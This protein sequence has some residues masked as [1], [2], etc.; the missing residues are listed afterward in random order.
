LAARVTAA[1]L[2]TLAAAAPAF[3]DVGSPCLEVVLR[4]PATADRR[5]VRVEAPGLAREA[6]ADS[7]G[8][9]V[10]FGLPP[11]SYRVQVV[12]P[13]ADASV[14]CSTNAV[15]PPDRD[16]RLELR[17]PP[18]VAAEESRVRSPSRT[19]FDAADLRS[20]PRP[21]NAWSVLREA[22]GVVLDR[23]D[24]GGSATAL[25]SLL[26][27]HGD[28][29]TG[30]TW[31]LDGVDVTDPA[32]PG[33]PLLYPPLDPLEAMVAQTG[34]TDVHARTPGVQVAL[35]S[36]APEDRPAGRLDVRF[37]PDALQSDNL[38]PGLTGRSLARGHTEQVLDLAAEAGLPVGDR[39]WVW[40]SASRYALDQTA[41][42]GHEEKLRTASLLG[43]AR[44][45]LGSGT[46]SALVLR[47]EKTDDDRD[48]TLQTAPEARWRQSGATW[49]ASLRDERALGS[50]TLVSR[51]A[52]VHGG[53]RLEPRGGSAASVFEDVT[54][55]TQRSY[56]RFET[57]RERLQAGT[58]ATARRSFLGFRHDLTT[59]VGYQRAP[60]AIR[61]SWPGNGT[62]GIESGGV[63]F[64]TFRLTGFAVA[65]RDLAAESIQDQWQA[66]MQ[67]TARRGRTTLTLGARLD[68]LAGRNR[69]AS[70]VSNPEFPA[71][72]PAVA[73][74]GSNE[75]FSWV[76]LLPRVG[77][78]FD[79]AGSGRLVSSARYAAYAAPLGSGDVTF[80][81]PLAA[82][83]STTWYWIDR[84]GDHTVERGEL[85]A[86]R[87]EIGTSGID[88]DHPGSA[89]PVNTI[90][91]ALGAPRTHELAA[92]LSWA[93]GRA[94]DL[95]FEACY[96]RLVDALW[97]PLI[98]LTSAD[99]VATGTVTGTLFGQSYSRAFYAPATTSRLTPGYGRELTNRD[100]YRQE[101]VTLTLGAGG[102]AFCRLDWRAWGAFTDWWE[103]FPDRESAVQDPTPLDAEPLQDFG[104]V[105]VSPGGLGRG[106]LFVG[107]RWMAGASLLARLPWQLEAAL[108]VSARD[109]FPIPYLQV[110]ST[111]D[112]TAGS[113]SV[114]IA[115]AVDTYRL[116]SLLLADARLARGFGLGPGRLTVSLDVF[117]LANAST[118]LQVARDVELAGFDRTREIV[119]PRIF[120]LGLSWL[121]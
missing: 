1:A 70:V 92:G 8:R 24:V 21:Q 7:E 76:D 98:G 30:A 107:A 85:D 106:D 66:W 95:S 64:R 19:A 27:S 41:F 6:F 28:D 94:L 89:L 86:T 110:G 59:G 109:G 121:F 90:D 50:V 103:R 5:S 119:R 26:V 82:G 80:D 97:Q 55:L 114:L 75:R 69:A 67:D 2:A 38:P 3:T 49:V 77:V 14:A 44:L 16:L 99:Y 36:R 12:D 13:A 62:L 60:V 52:W 4:E 101:S 120:R 74:Q 11:G 102:R 105:V 104:R 68:R 31:T 53:F 9:V 20:R 79:V 58:E 48:P 87:G 116:P 56:A 43:R 54:G 33:T 42:T 84:N 40:G 93:P 91:P 71:L 118:E 113:K 108:V 61:Q 73:F 29:G 51:L 72:L 88:P 17:C 45:R 96:R 46:L 47:S 18:S 22:P 57:E 115:P 34:G 35:F 78:S 63:F 81:N 10:F 112:P 32:S 117:N 111:G 15:M 39:L 83:A 65:Y 100:G 23:V 25:S 37:A